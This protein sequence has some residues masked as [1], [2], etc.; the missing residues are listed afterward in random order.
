[1]LNRYSRIRGTQPQEHEYR[2]P[3]REPCVRQDHVHNQGYRLHQPGSICIEYRIVSFALHIQHVGLADT[4]SP[5]TRT[6]T[7]EAPPIV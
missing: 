1:M 4:D 7:K 5:S 6:V 3:P 2:I